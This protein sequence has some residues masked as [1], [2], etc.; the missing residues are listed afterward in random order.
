MKAVHR[1]VPGR[2]FALLF[3]IAALQ[4]AQ[5][6]PTAIPAVKDTLP[7]LETLDDIPGVLEFLAPVLLPKVIP[8]GTALKEFIKSGEFAAVRASFGDKHAVDVLFRRAQ[9]I[10]WNNTWGALLIT[11]LATMDHRRIAFNVP[12]FGPMLWIPLSSEFEDEF[13]YRVRALPRFVFPDSPESEHGDVDKLQ[14]FFGSAFLAFCS[15]SP[16]VVERFG[17]FVEWGEEHFVPGGTTDPR[18]LCA[19][20]WGSRFGLSLMEDAHSRPSTFFNSAL[21][22]A[23]DTLRTQSLENQR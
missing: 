6:Q 3:I 19:N 17:G 18:D 10:S 16:D 13:Q 20:L 7:A 12:L 2:L 8:D 1:F 5:C 22:E 14:H 23:P 4:T 21:R 9:K 11:L 15:R